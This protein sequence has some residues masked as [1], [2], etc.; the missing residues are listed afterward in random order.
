MLLD[1]S[2]A[3]ERNPVVAAPPRAHLRSRLFREPADDLEIPVDGPHGGPEGPH[4]PHPGAGDVTRRKY[5]GQRCGRRDTAL[6]EVLRS[7][8]DEK[9]GRQ[10]QEQEYQST[11]RA[12]QTQIEPAANTTLVAGSEIMILTMERL[13]FCVGILYSYFVMYLVHFVCLNLK[14]ILRLT[15]DYE[16][17]ARIFF[18]VS[19]FGNF[20]GSILFS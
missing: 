15:S 18:R 9:V 12:L 11:R 6:L 16:N 1:I 20:F 19:V 13:T 14:C 4:E 7:G 2:G 17:F 3:G 5:G 10:R 8:Q